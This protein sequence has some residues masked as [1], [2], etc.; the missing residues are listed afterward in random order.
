MDTPTFR[1]PCDAGDVVVHRGATFIGPL[2]RD[3][4]GHLQA[5]RAVPAADGGRLVTRVSTPRD[6]I[7]WLTGRP[8]EAG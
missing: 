4:A 6:G 8:V 3:A 1:N 2:V 5:Q 7:A